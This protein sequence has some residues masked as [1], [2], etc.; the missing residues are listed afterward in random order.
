[1]VSVV[2]SCWKKE[3]SARRCHSLLFF[4]IPHPESARSVH[5]VFPA[6]LTSSNA[7][8]DACCKLTE[9]TANNRPSEDFYTSCFQSHP[10]WRP[11]SSDL[12]T[13]P[14]FLEGSLDTLPFTNSTLSTL[15]FSPRVPH[16]SRFSC[17]NLNRWFRNLDGAA[18]DLWQ[19]QWVWKEWT[20]KIS[21]ILFQDFF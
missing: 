18:E 5:T 21:I 7:G 13:R 19:S 3:T 10:S 12:S 11:R 14:G 17:S 15:A 9:V 20:W 8:P 4:S 2:Y 1:M 16:P 6:L